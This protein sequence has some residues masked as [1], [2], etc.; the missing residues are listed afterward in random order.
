MFDAHELFKNRLST[1]IKEMNRYLRYI[2]MGI[3]P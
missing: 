1:H 3:L 2:L